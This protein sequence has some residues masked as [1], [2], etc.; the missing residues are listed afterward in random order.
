MCLQK[1]EP[2]KKIFTCGLKSPMGIYSMLG[3]HDYGDYVEWPSAASKVENPPKSWN[4]IMPTLGCDWWW[5]SILFSKKKDRNGVTGCWK[6]EQPGPLPKHGNLAQAY[7]G[8]KEQDIRKNIDEPRS[9]HWDAQIHKE[10]TKSIDLT[11]SGLTTA[12]SSVL[13]YPIGLKWARYSMFTKQWAGMY[14]E[15]DQ[16]LNV[17]VGYGFLGYPGRHGAYYR[18]YRFWT[19]IGQTV[20]TIAD[21]IGEYNLIAFCDA[22]KMLSVIS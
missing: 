14:R 13:N 21:N 9:T 5:M 3:N 16:Y 7:A 4:N 1:I 22:Y 15:A 6:L 17:S 10:T 12:C 18:R 20:N 2:Y 19:Y 8:L 11:L